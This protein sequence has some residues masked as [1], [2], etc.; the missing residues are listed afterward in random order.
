MGLGAS[1]MYSVVNLALTDIVDLRGGPYHTWVSGGEPV[2]LRTVRFFAVI[3]T[4]LA[5][6]PA[7]AHF[8]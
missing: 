3:L 1:K 4:A 7:G 6:V 8:F 5:L 2:I